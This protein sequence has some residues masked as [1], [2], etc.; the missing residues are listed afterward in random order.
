MRK[1]YPHVSAVSAQNGGTGF[2][3]WPCRDADLQYN[4]FRDE[5][6]S[7]R[8]LERA[9][10]NTS[11]RDSVHGYA[12]ALTVPSVNSY[13]GLRPVV[14]NFWYPLAIDLRVTSLVT[15]QT[16][17]VEAKGENHPSCSPPYTGWGRRWG[18]RLKVTRK[19]K[20]W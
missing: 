1:R 9:Q 11:L 10:G 4:Y 3:S 5:P 13:D 2:C 12:V 17:T 6:V 15:S 20:G 16:G 18:C 7:L 19:V 8:L 14:L